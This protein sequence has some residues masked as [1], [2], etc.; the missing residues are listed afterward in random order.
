MLIVIGLA[1]VIVFAVVAVLVDP[2][3]GHQASYD[4]RNDLPFWAYLGRR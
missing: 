4:P 2:A 3:D 1:A